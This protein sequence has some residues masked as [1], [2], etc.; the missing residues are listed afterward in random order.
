LYVNFFQ[1]QENLA[2]TAMAQDQRSGRVYLLVLKVKDPTAALVATDRVS[3]KLLLVNSWCP[4]LDALVAP[5]PPRNK[6]ALAHVHIYMSQSKL[7]TP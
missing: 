3:L 7:C 2:T 4:L 5:Q 1:I 6:V